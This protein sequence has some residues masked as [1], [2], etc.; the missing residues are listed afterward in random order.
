[1]IP[2]PS[3]EDT[4]GCPSGIGDLYKTKYWK[5]VGIGVNL[6]HTCSS[7]GSF[8]IPANAYSY[9]IAHTGNA[10]VGTYFFKLA[11]PDSQRGYVT[12]KL[13]D[14]L[15]Q[16]KKYVSSC[17][18]NLGD[19]FQYSI[20]TIGMYFSVDSVSSTNSIFLPLMPQ[21]ENHYGSPVTDTLNWTEIIDTIVAQGGE[22]YL[23]IG[24]FR[25]DSL[26][27][28]L[29]VFGSQPTWLT[30]F[31]FIDDV[32]VIEYSDTL[33]VFKDRDIF[34]EK[35]IVFPNP[36]D[37]NLIVQF[38][39]EIYESVSFLIIDNLGRGIYS[40]LLNGKKVESINLESINNGLYYYLFRNKTGNIINKGKLVLQK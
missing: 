17:F 22:Q 20:S 14:S 6:Y 34:K 27:D 5:G 35:I 2:N 33:N 40:G 12:V 13:T 21:V 31:Y 25:S 18:V 4:I 15:R 36:T 37:H 19:K 38:S 3:F 26:S 32:S 28:T 11:Y 24:N 1:M 23:T 30:S 29:R 8:G 39:N 16:G 7:S 9:Q 10:F